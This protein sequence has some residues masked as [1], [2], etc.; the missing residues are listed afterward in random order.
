MRKAAELVL[1]ESKMVEESKKNQ[2]E[3][4]ALAAQAVKAAK[5]Q[6]YRDDR[7]EHPFLRD[8]HDLFITII[9]IIT[10]IVIIFEYNYNYNYDYN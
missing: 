3:Q 9:I 7:S 2:V 6:S 1:E 5:V 10:M 8:P 4:M